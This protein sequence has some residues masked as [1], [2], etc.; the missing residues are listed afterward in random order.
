MWRSDIF[1]CGRIDAPQRASQPLNISIQHAART[2]RFFLGVRKSVLGCPWRDRLDEA[3]QARALAMTQE[4]AFPDILSRVLAGRGV[5]AATAQAYLTP[6]IRSLLPEPESL[7]DMA[8]AA[9]RLARAVEEGETVGIIGDYDVDGA[10]SAALMAEFLLKA[11]AAFRIHIPDRIYEGYG[12]NIE[13]VRSLAQAG[14]KLI[15]TVDCGTTSHAPLAEAA[16]LGLDVIVIDHHQAPEALPQALAIVNPNRQDDLSGLSQLC[17]AGV[18]FVV[19]VALNR[20]LRRR[21]FWTATRPEPDLLEMLDL[22]ALG[23]VADVVPLVGLN[24]AFVVKG[25]A[26]MRA[27]RRPG[28]RALMDVS[29]ADGPARPY[30]LGFLLGPRINAGG[31]IGDP[32]LGAKLLIER[33]EEVGARLAADLDRLNRERQTVEFATLAAAEA[34]AMASLGLDERGATIVTAGAGWHPGVVGLVAARLRERYRRPAFA[35]AFDGEIGT[36]SGRSITEVDL[37]RVVRAAVEAGILIKGGGHAMAAGITIAAPRL[38]D[39]RAF[40]EE[41][42]GPAVA[43]ARASEALAVDAALTAGAATVDLVAAFEPAGPFGAG[44]PEPVFAF[45]MHRILDVATVGSDHVRLSAAAGDGSRISAIAFRASGS[46]LGRKLIE[47]RG[48]RLHL[49]G[50]LSVD[51]RGGGARAQLKLLDAAEPEQ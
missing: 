21:G 18:V 24:R 3:G 25:L 12:P 49:A 41:R 10:T 9:A 20:E 43:R 42:I 14:A 30:T 6:S 4:L 1:A 44:N 17:A 13:A 11:G 15:V 37:G 39:F 2:E 28:L 22:V 38:G 35:I 47:G 48:E 7:T 19:L 5:N 36:G 32:A 29:G 16:R 23:T 34:E 45:P 27:R 46:A 51:R 50:T 31:R 33:D 26:V 8:G 40:L